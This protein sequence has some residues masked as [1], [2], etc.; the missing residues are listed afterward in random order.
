LLF[1]FKGELFSSY[2]FVV[3]LIIKIQEY[4]LIVYSKKYRELC[5][6]IE[7]ASFTL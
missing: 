1:D 5:V 2:L 4:N 6:Y 3:E 7:T